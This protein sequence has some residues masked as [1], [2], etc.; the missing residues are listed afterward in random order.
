[1][2]GQSPQTLGEAGV[3]VPVACFVV[4][5]VWSITIG[6]IVVCCLASMVIAIT[7]LT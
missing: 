2:T 3:S 6:I 4:P 5:A 1:M 7:K